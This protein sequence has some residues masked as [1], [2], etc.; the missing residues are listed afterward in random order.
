MALSRQ[1]ATPQIPDGTLAAVPMKNPGLCTDLTV[2]PR[3]C[4]LAYRQVVHRFDGETVVVSVFLNR[5]LWTRTRGGWEPPR[6][7]WLSTSSLGGVVVYSST[8]LVAPRNAALGQGHAPS[9]SGAAG[10]PHGGRHSQPDPV[11]LHSNPAAHAPS[12]SGA[13]ASPHH[14]V[15]ASPCRRVVAQSDPRLS[16]ASR[17]LCREMRRSASQ[18]SP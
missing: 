17:F 4:L 13:G 9:H 8:P 6:R 3:G 5:R 16:R 12:H 2:A 10:S 14:G 15:S 11:S 7:S 18:P 1:G